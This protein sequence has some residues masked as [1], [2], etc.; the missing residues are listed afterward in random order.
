MSRIDAK[1]TTAPETMAASVPIELLD[2]TGRSLGIKLLD[3]LRH[4]AY[5]R[6]EPRHGRVWD[7]DTEEK[8]T[9]LPR[10][11][12]LLRSE[13]VA[14]TLRHTDESLTSTTDHGA[15]CASVVLAGYGSTAT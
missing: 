10:Q 14:W 8:E 7:V 15:V 13:V 3:D 1:Q 11:D 4:A 2:V 5:R 12:R 6:A 9:R